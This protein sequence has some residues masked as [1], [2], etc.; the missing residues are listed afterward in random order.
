MIASGLMEKLTNGSH[1]PISIGLNTLNRCNVSCIMCPPAI[2]L[3]RGGARSKYYRLTLEEY[4]RITDGVRIEMAHF[5]GAY[6]E[7]FLNKELFD[8]IYYAKSCGS[9]T[10]ITTNAT[11]L[12]ERARKKIVELGVDTVTISMHGA[13][14]SVAEGIM[15]GSDFYKIL[16]NIIKFGELRRSTPNNCTYVMANYIGMKRNIRDFPAF[17]YL[18]KMANINQVNLVH[19][20]D[21]GNETAEIGKIENLVNHPDLLREIWP[22]C[23]K[24]AEYLGLFLRLDPAYLEIVRDYQE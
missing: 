18:A 14:R 20:I 4:K 9:K 21:G 24:L 8:I 1:L 11:L 23:K 3:A 16:D 17:L 5:V 2:H 15:N 19:L 6:A 13:T 10:A 22:N 7:P 12:D